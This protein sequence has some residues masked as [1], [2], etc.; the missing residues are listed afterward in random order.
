MRPN[1]CRNSR[2]FSG[3]VSGF[4]FDT[5]ILGLS[6]FTGL[7]KGVA[8]DI[9]VTGLDKGVEAFDI[10]VTGLDK[11]VALDIFPPFLEVVL[12]V[13]SSKLTPRP[14]RSIAAKEDDVFVEEDVWVFV[15][16]EAL[17][18]SCSLLVLLF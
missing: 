18:W 10:L 11:E 4:R 6:A 14:G 12:V 3:L 17:D 8:F 9:L 7:D 5:K 13:E 15:H 2:T 16:V 1:F